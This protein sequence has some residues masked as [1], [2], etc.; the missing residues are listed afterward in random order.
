MKK[1]ALLFTSL[2]SVGLLA[3][4]T[5]DECKVTFDTGEG[6]CVIAPQVVKYEKFATEPEGDITRE[7]T[8]QY[9]YTFIEW[10]LDGEKYEF[11][12][13]VTRDITLVA[14]WKETLR[15]YTVY[16]LHGG[17]EPID[18]QTVEYGKCATDPGTPT[19]RDSPFHEYTF[20]EWQL[21]GTK[22]N[23]DT[24]VTQDIVLKA[25]WNCTKTK[26]FVSFLT[27]GGTT[28][29]PLE[30][31]YG[32]VINKPAD[33]EKQD[34]KYKYKFQG[35]HKIL[36]DGRMDENEFNFNTP[37]QG[38]TFL[39]ATYTIDETLTYHVSAD[40][41]ERLKF[42]TM[43]G[44]AVS[45][46]EVQ[47]GSEFQFKM[48]AVNSSSSNDIRYSVPD[49]I[50]LKIR[51]RSFIGKGYTI[52]YDD[53]FRSSATVTIKTGV[54]DG[55]VTI[56]GEVNISSYYT[57]KGNA[58]GCSFNAEPYVEQGQNS[59]IQFVQNGVLPC[60]SKN[61]IL[62]KVDATPGSTWVPL[63]TRED[64][65]EYNETT[66]ELL[67]K[68]S[69]VPVWS[70]FEFL[71]YSSGQTCFEA[72]PWNFIREIAYTFIP[73]TGE[74][75]Q[76]FKVGDTKNICLKEN[77]HAQSFTHQV[78]IIGINCDLLSDGTRN[79]PLT[80][81]FV[82]LIT[83]GDGRPTLIKRNPNNYNC[84]FED[85]P[86][87]VSL[88]NRG[89]PSSIASR[90]PD[91]LY[92]NL[93][94]VQKRVGIGKSYSTDVPY[95]TR[96]FP[97]A[98][99]EI[100]RVPKEQYYHPPSGEG[101]RYEYYSWDDDL[102]RRTKYPATVSSAANNLHEDCEQRYWLRSPTKGE[103]ELAFSITDINESGWDPGDLI[104]SFA[105]D[106]CAVAPAFCI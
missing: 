50:D 26:Y 97:L 63:S 90:I 62:I 13:P 72:L 19:H 55:D 46:V 65:C 88:T 100:S 28:I 36:D 8:A 5:P 101:G 30:V 3:N 31:E 6:G 17:M 105:S 67:I 54:I 57:V 95:S 21:N 84:S 96:L 51:N 69:S 27:D 20:N 71:A 35:W 45:Y 4:C 75:P 89:D 98:V 86:L 47:A 49:S 34:Y 85:G 103:D 56:T 15:K 61:E 1:V 22:Y 44:W 102:N 91:D 82:N 92:G 53:E 14:K 33:P 58:F 10:Q 87:N 83:N 81:E 23:F 74:S 32:A 7:S 93:S 78:R 2:M 12:T 70:S 68:A 42:T 66:H 25:D 18:P 59:I 9:D 43:D 106:Q 60:P 52:D 64:L 41:T 16:F 76:Y 80:L 77:G 99:D 39:K 37:I 24:P 29:N 94:V 79:A 73:Y 40:D 38:D 11:N 104:V 48:K